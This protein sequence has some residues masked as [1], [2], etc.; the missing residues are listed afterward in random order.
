MNYSKLVLLI[1]LGVILSGCLKAS[2]QQASDSEQSP[3]IVTSILNKSDLQETEKLVLLARIA[4][5]TKDDN[6]R[7]ASL[8]AIEKI[9]FSDKE[10]GELDT[11]GKLLQA[12]LER[13]GLNTVI[14]DTRQDAL[15][16]VN[17]VLQSDLEHAVGKIQTG[18]TFSSKA[19]VAEK[20]SFNDSATNIFLPA[21]GA[22]S[23]LGPITPNAYGPG[24]NSDATGRPFTY[25]P[26]FG[27]SGFP[28]P[29]LKVKPN[30]YGPGV[31]MDQYGRPVRPSSW[32]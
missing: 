18:D 13:R 3:K 2:K 32:P 27:A 8:L 30:A 28:G 17:L 25:Q 10:P 21:P 31:G 20:S 11:F 9:R 24:I 6:E 26:D 23:F 7:E 5:S 29:T 15:K 1:F 12:R 14:V 4:Y 16:I 19:S 22:Q